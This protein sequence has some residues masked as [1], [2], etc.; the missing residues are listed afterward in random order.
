[1]IYLTKKQL[2]EIAQQIASIS[3]KDSDFDE[4]ENIQ[5]GD[6]V[7]IIQ[8]GINKRILI[9]TLREGIA[10]GDKGDPG[11]SAY[12][13]WQD[14]GHPGGTIEEYFADIKGEPGE[15][16]KDGKDGQDGQDGHDGAPGVGVPVGGTTGQVLAKSSNSDYATTWVNQSGGGT[17]VQSDWNQSDTNAVDYIKNKPTIPSSLNNLTDVT[18]SSATNNQVL[19]YNGSAWVNAAAPSGGASALDDLS[20]VTLTTPSSGQTLSYNGS[21]WVNAAVGTMQ[22]RKVTASEYNELSS[23]GQL[24][25]NVL[26]VVVDDRQSGVA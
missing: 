8:D 2:E 17:Q 11:E 25:N 9:S 5:D 15:D 24:V 13:V 19:K 6:S 23:N 12:E 21:Q 26:Y 4:T 1:M 18:I 16:G 22:Y 20:D 3:V 7:A 14:N 10:K